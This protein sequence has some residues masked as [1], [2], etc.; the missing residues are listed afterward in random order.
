MI[1]NI[2]TEGLYSAGSLVFITAGLFCAYIRWNHMCKPFCENPD[3]FYPARK[4]VTLFFA[5]IVL[6]FPYVL[7]PMDPAV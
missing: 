5:S 6:T 1:W 3:Y 2:T 4:L 7:A